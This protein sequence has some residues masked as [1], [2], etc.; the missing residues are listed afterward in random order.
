MRIAAS[1]FGL[2]RCVT[3]C[4]DCHAASLK[5]LRYSIEQGGS[6]AEPRH[7]RLLEDTIEV[8]SVQVDFV[9]RHSIST[10]FGASVCAQV[11]HQCADSCAR[12][13]TDP[14]LQACAAACRSFGLYCFEMVAGTTDDV[15]VIE[16]WA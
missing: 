12:W 14:I 13:D 11:C 5:A 3:E 10:A 9:L 6:F 4:N 15:A 2:E 1:I 16:T 7:L 8:C